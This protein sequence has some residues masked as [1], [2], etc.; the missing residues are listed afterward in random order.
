MGRFFRIISLALCLEL[1]TP[2]NAALDPAQTWLSSHPRIAEAIRWEGKN[3]P[4]KWKDWPLE[5]KETLSQTVAAAI[6]WQDPHAASEAV[7]GAPLPNQL[8]LGDKD[9]V[10]TVLSE[11]DAW[12]L[13]S[14][15][16]ASSIALELKHRLP[17]SLNTLNRSDLE[18]L[19]D[20]RE[21]F[22]RR[23]S[24]DG[25][26]LDVK[27]SGYVLPE[28]PEETFTFLAHEELIGRSRRET[29]VRVIGWAKTLL[30]ET[31]PRALL[32]QGYGPYS[33]RVMEGIWGYRGFPPVGGILGGSAQRI[34]PR[35]PGW[36]HWTAGCW[37]TTGLLRA[38]LRVVNIPVEQTAIAGHSQPHFP[39][40]RLFL[41]HGDDPY[42]Q[43]VTTSPS[44]QASEAILFDEGNWSKWFP[45]GSAV[46]NIGLGPALLAVSSLSR[47]LVQDYCDD[48]RRHLTRDTG[49]VYRRLRPYFTLTDLERRELWPRLARE[50]SRTG[51]CNGKN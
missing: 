35:F 31:M 30:H 49:A 3:G 28:F 6:L 36:R 4:R 1:G 51:A 23:R 34:D 38:M 41:T 29:I 12:R 15:H 42:D 39:S 21:F 22:E 40:E 13:Y 20:S 7:F 44:N 16:V 25:Y 2:T 11:P 17:W 8:E 37:G 18:L 24:A 14:L 47:V 9:D 46:K 10:T 5:K 19:F 43:M 48:S 45:G 27:R 50:A 26:A 32:A 33:A